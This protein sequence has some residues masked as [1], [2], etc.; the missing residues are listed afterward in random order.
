MRYTTLDDRHIERQ[1]TDIQTD[2]RICDDIR[3]I[4]VV[5]FAYT[6]WIT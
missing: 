2:R 5:A 4:N 6:K 1:T 3:R